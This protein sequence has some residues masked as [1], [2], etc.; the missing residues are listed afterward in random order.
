MM[1][2]LIYIESSSEGIDSL[3]KQVAAGVKKI[4]PELRGPLKGISIGNCLEGKEE[5]A[6]GI[7]DELIRIDVPAELE[8]NTETI[9][10]IL[11]S[12]VQGDAPA[13]LFL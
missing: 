5:L 3:T 7:F 10:K 11:T 2:S 6:K 13:L 12:L 1:Q 8:F 9:S 4:H